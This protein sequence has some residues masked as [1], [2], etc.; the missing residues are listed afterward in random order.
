M[1]TLLRYFIV[2]DCFFA[3]LTDVQT[4]NVQTDTPVQAPVQIIN[5]QSIEALNGF[6]ILAEAARTMSRIVRE[7]DKVNVI[8]R[9]TLDMPATK[10]P[11]LISGIKIVRIPDSAKSFHVL[12]HLAK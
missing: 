2:C 9:L 4:N 7:F 3:E 1:S 6:D 11:P 5:I 10:G 8:D 12:V